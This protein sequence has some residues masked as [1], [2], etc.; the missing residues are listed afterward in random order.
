MAN[1]KSAQ[2]RIKQAKKRTARNRTYKDNIKEASKKLTAL[3]QSG[4]VDE[5]GKAYSQLQKSVDKAAKNRVLQK[6][7]AARIKS[8]FSKLTTKS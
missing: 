5:L 7:T 4:T 3:A 2:K 6:N 8:R 1:I